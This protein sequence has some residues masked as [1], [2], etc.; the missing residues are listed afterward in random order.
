MDL[1]AMDKGKISLGR[2]DWIK[3]GGAAAIASSLPLIGCAPGKVS[4]SR[5][6]KV[7][8]MVADGMSAGVPSMAEKFSRLTRNSG[9]AWQEM[10]AHRETTHGFFETSSL[11]SG[12]TDSAAASS[13][14]SSGSKIFNRMINMLPDGRPLEPIGRLV[15]QKGWKLGLVT[16]C[17]VTHATP[18][19][20]VAATDNRDD[21]QGIAGQYLDSVDVVMGGGRA[22]FSGDLRDDGRDLVGEFAGRGYGVLFHKDDLKS[23]GGKNKLLGLFDYSHLPFTLDQSRSAALA[24]RVPSL[25]QMASVALDALAASSDNFLLQ[26]EG[27]RVDH[28]AHRNDAAGLLW[29]QIAFDDA[30]RVAWDFAR[31]HPDTLL[32]V[33]TDHGNGN[34][35]LCGMGYEYITS[36]DC[37]A[38]LAGFTGTVDQF[39]LGLRQDI[40]AGRKA[41]DAKEFAGR[42]QVMTGFAMPE[43]TVAELHAAFP[44]ALKEKHGQ[45]RCFLEMFGRYLGDWTGIQWS[46]LEHT[47]DWALSMAWGAGSEEFKGLLANTDVCGRIAVFAGVQHQNTKMTVEEALQYRKLQPAVM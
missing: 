39:Y 34:P 37:F 11:S 45:R 36:N 12:V 40:L 9:T 14:W 24:G 6:R 2:R 33:T 46:G 28:A 5:V 38:R 17:T 31:K 43:K 20:F 29:E 18:A 47:S 1:T 27:G 42:L 3:L 10:S 22:F 13:A 23:A 8:F 32:V 30:V 15:R 16:T 19:G 21:E 4:R 7:I 25:A 26:I 35:G 41:P 44:F